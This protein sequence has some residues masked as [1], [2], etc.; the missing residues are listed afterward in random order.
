[1]LDFC[2]L[3]AWID[4]IDR[5]L[6]FWERA[7]SP[8]RVWTHSLAYSKIMA[9]EICKIK[10]E[11]IQTPEEYQTRPQTDKDRARYAQFLS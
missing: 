11:K 4:R 1:M 5:A 7:A 10:Y 9:I 3:T 6:P 2:Q 8:A